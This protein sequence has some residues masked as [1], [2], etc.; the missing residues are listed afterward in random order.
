VEQHL[1]LFDMKLFSI[2]C[3][4]DAWVVD[5]MSFKNGN[6]H[7]NIFFTR[8]VVFVFFKLLYSQKVRQGVEDKSYWIP[9]KRKLFEVKTYYH[10]L[11]TS[12][13]FPFPWKCIW[14]VKS[15]SKVMFFVWTAA[16]GKI[17]TLDNF[18]R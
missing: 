3:C 17:L 10:V 12:V 6:I 14:K 13:S 4:K 18:G 2:S 15:P 16:L 8:L 9:F 11:S 1:K 7:W 5:Y